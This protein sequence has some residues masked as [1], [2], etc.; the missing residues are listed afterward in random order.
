[1]ATI[2]L[3]PYLVNDCKIYSDKP[4]I[5]IKTSY[6]GVCTLADII[7]KY[8]NVS[9]IIL[10]YKPHMS[11]CSDFYYNVTKGKILPHGDKTSD[12][13]DDIAYFM[14]D[15]MWNSIT[16][17]ILYLEKYKEVTSVK[18]EG[19]IFEITFE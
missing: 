3:H 18:Y 14:C 2:I 10:K 11:T 5:G 8:C 15:R 16:C 6:T 9:A 4:L 19:D 17:K 13:T 1:M 12:F 7:P